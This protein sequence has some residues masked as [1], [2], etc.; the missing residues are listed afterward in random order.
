MIDH[1]NKSY[2]NN[3]IKKQQIKELVSCKLYIFIRSTPSELE[4]QCRGFILTRLTM[5][6]AAC[7]MWI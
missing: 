7:C 6:F 1:Q 2:P 5:N 4:I 3:A